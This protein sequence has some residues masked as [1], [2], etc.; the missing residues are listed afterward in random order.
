VPQ[1]APELREHISE[2][3]WAHIQEVMRTGRPWFDE[4]AADALVVPMTVANRRVGVI[5]MTF[6]DVRGRLSAPD[7]IVGEEFG[8]RA[9]LALE[10]VSLYQKARSAVALREEF[11]SIASHELRTPLATLQLHLQLLQRKAAQPF[12]SQEASERVQKCVNQTGR[13]ARLI[14]TLLDVSLISSGQIT[15]KT[16]EVDLS[17]LIHETVE[18]FHAE[19]NGTA[20][21]LR[22]RDGVQ[23]KGLW[24]RLRLEQVVT[25][26]IANGIKYG[27]GAPVEVVLSHEEAEAIITVRDGGI[28][29]AKEDLGRIFERFQ[30]AASARNYSGLGLGLYV[31]RQIVEAHGG[32][33]AVESEEGSGSLFTVRLPLRARAAVCDA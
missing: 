27:A 18:R 1:K 3:E 10:N 19:T 33:I 15:L 13:L 31:T 14:D 22:F 6:D 30:R 23:A 12:S 32:T 9:A 7:R 26:L 25:N 16:E 20:G 2:A 28:G 8:H 5:S 17:A 4:D 24:D 11:L 29:I 21:A